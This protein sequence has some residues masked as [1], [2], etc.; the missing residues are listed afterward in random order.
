MK[1]ESRKIIYDTEEDYYALMDGRRHELINGIIYDMAS[2]GS[3]HQLIS[4]HLFHA[5]F[6]HILENGG[7]CKVF[8]APYDV[9]LFPDEDGNIVQ[10]DLLVVCDPKKIRTNRLEG[11]PDWIIEIA[12]KSS[13]SHDY[14]TKL[15]LY[16]EAGVREYWIVDP[17]KSKIHVF[18]LES[19]EFSVVCFTFDDTVE[20]GILPGLN[21]DFKAISDSI[22]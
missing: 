20:S 12:S 22:G 19:E 2:P 13:L 18:K 10:P 16:K 3:I 6:S 7:P 8:Y 5:I 4:G 21:L 14:V 17:D 1:D 15:N 9:K 11:A